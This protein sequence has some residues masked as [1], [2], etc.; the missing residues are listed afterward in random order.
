MGREG[1]GVSR[2]ARLGLLALI[3]TLLCDQALKLWLMFGYDLPI[4]EPVAV[5]GFM[6]LVVVWNRGI[7]YGLFQQEAAFGRWLLVAIHFGAALALGIWMMRAP[8][9][10]LAIGLGL[11]AGGALGNGID[12]IAYGAVFDFVHLHAAGYSWYVF[13]VADAAIVAG[14]A[15]LLYDSVVPGRRSPA[16]VTPAGNDGT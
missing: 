2:A 10:A 13:N 8:G 9:R 4:R 14:V 5:T 15:M 6:N 11:I 1:G 7:S 12:R 16:G 3:A